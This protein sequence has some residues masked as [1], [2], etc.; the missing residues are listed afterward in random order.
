MASYYQ[1]YIEANKKN[2]ADIKTASASPVRTMKNQTTTND[3]A[4]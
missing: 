3:P 2:A 4:V 1:Q